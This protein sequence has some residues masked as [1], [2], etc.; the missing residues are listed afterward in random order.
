MRWRYTMELSPIFYFTTGGKNFGIFQQTV[1]EK[2][3]FMVIARMEP[4][5]VGRALVR[6]GF[7][8]DGMYAQRDTDGDGIIKDAD[9]IEPVL[10]ADG[11]RIAAHIF[12]GLF[13]TD[14]RR[15]GSLALITGNGMLFVPLLGLD[16]AGVPKYDFAHR[17]DVPGQ[18]EGTPNYISPYEFKT[19][20][21][22]SIGNDLYCLDD[23]GFVAAMRTA[24]GPGPDPA[25][26]HSNGTSMAGF[27]GKG[28]LRW[29]SPMNPYGLK[30][31]FHGI[32]HIGGITIAGRG[33]LCEFE[34]M[35]ADG[36]GTGVLG[37]PRAFGWGGMWLDNHRQ[38]QGFTGNDGKP[39]LIVGDYAEQ[40][41]HWLALTGND[42]LLHQSQRVTVTPATAAAL[43]AEPAAPVP[44]WP[45]PPAPRVTIKK[46]AAALPIDGELA[47]WRALGIA[48][49]IIS[50]DDPTD[51]SAVVRMGY[52]DDALFVQV[53]K[54]DNALTFH[55]TEPGRHYQQDGIEFNIGTFWSGWKY[56]V[57]RL[58]WKNDIILR[59][60]F[61]G[62]SR[63]LTPEEAPRVIK[64]L[65]NAADVPE[66][67]LL[68]AA[69]G[70]DMSKCK[71]MVIEMKL[72]QPALA[73]LPADRAVS[74]QSGKTFLLGICINDNDV[75][76]GDLF[77]PI[78]WPTGY[79]AFS[80]DDGLATA[81]ME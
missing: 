31:G 15:D 21:S 58:D 36:L 56:N 40:S 23:G 6:Y 11:K 63:L 35:D 79:G 67:K 7:D 52:A 51:N 16:A 2:G 34:T 14:T 61:F 59:D 28:Q 73:G 5:G 37:T 4:E 43:L 3:N 81:V 77:A 33:Q 70:A 18:V 8:K 75:V 64:V 29:F 53:I 68:E 66:R 45:V 78:G 50:A 12:D 48:P 1:K 57:T 65:D 72:G 26:E 54:F 38:V 20:E 19:K 17:R 55:Q 62:E 71:V 44:V 10:E 24:T 22:I 39:Y 41:Y 47:K 74:F 42:K 76:G 80:R 32:A 60:R 25:T 46:L 49:I 13:N 9:P 30:L 69:T 27:D